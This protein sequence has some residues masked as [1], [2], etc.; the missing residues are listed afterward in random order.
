MVV[1]LTTTLWAAVAATAGLAGTAVAADTTASPSPSSSSSPS[2]SAPAP[3]TSLFL[4]GVDNAAELVASVVSVK[5]PA[6][7]YRVECAKDADEDAC[8]AATEGISV[9]MGPDSY[10]LGIGEPVT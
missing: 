4:P 6:T 2:S 7:Y 1:K 9:T 3:V 10:A 5:A 8:G